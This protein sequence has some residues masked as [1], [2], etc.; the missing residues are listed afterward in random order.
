MPD[1]VQPSEIGNA[2]IDGRRLWH[3]LYELWLTR[4]G[5][6]D[7]GG[8][9]LEPVAVAENEGDGCVGVACE[10]AGN[11]GVIMIAD[12]NVAFV[13]GGWQFHRIRLEPSVGEGHDCRLAP[14]CA[15]GHAGLAVGTVYIG[16]EAQ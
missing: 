8:S 2:V 10:W 3:I 9:D 4:K 11:Q 16:M 13:N 7:A 1:L 5:D 6:G 12:A 14:A 15:R